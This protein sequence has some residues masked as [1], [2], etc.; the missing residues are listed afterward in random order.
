M[1]FNNQIGLYKLYYMGKGSSDSSIIAGISFYN[2]SN[3]YLGSVNFY[4]DGQ[5]IPDNSSIESATPKRAYLKM[6][7]RQID[8]VVDMLRNEK[9][10]LIRYIS[11]TYAYISTGKEPTGEEESEE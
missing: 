10:C 9:P 8:S 4:R 5:N 2:D 1:G 7:E 3:Q 6:H 11:P